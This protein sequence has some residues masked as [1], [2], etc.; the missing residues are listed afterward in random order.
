[1]RA[2]RAA[3]GGGQ[4]GLASENRY[5]HATNLESG[6]FGD[7]RERVPETESFGIV[8]VGILTEK[9][10]VQTR[11]GPCLFRSFSQHEEICNSSGG[12]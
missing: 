12:L 10:R 1:M 3:D 6:L 4:E 7:R 8:C 9:P 5:T 11:A 2:M